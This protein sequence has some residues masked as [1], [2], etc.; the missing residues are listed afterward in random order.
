MTPVRIIAALLSIAALS[1][2]LAARAQ[3]A[4][5]APTYARP[6]VNGEE[7][8]RGRVNGFDGK[9]SLQ[10]RDDRGFIDNVQLHQGTII[11]PTGLSLQPG[12]PVTIA[13]YNRGRVFAANQIDTP[14]GSYG[15]VPAGYPAVSV[16]IG[17]G[18]VYYHRWH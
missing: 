16:G 2:P 10:V 1:T 18:P 12:M 13:G 15:F 17:F 8:I 14:Y 11:N 9:Y 5:S 4:P 3:Q 7:T 6:A